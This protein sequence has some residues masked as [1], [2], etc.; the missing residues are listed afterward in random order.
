[1][2]Y[3]YLF[4]SIKSVQAVQ[5]QSKICILDI[6]VQGVRTIKSG[7]SSAS[8]DPIYVFIAPPSMEALESRLRQRNTEEEA[9]ILKRLNNAKTELEYGLT[10][11]NFD[12]V[13][14]NDNLDETCSEIAK[15]LREWYPDLLGE[16]MQQP[17]TRK[18]HVPLVD[19]L[20]FPKTEHG[21]K[22][23]L[24]EID[25]DCQL[26]KYNQAHLTYQATGVHIK[27]GGKLE[28]PLPPVEQNGS[29]VEW[30]VTLLDE[31]LEGLDLEFGV[32]CIVD[33]DEVMV[34]QMRRI[35]SPS[36]SNQADEDVAATSDGVSS[37]GEEK[38][39]HEGEETPSAKGKF[40]VANSAPV[41]LFIKCDNS[42][43]W[44][45]PKKINYSFT[46][47]PP[48]DEDMIQRSNR[49]KSVL[50][51]ILEERAVVVGATLKLKERLDA[52]DRIKTDLL[53]KMDQLN[54]QIY[55]EK[56][57]IE[58]TRQRADEAEQTASS[59][60]QEIKDTLVAVKREE[61][62]IDSC[63]RQI[64]SLEEE[65]A[66]LKKQCEGLKI[67]RQVRLEEKTQLEMKAETCRQERIQL[68]G[69]I[70][71]RKAEEKTK[72]AALTSLEKD[73]LLMND[74]MN[75]LEKER[76]SKA[77]E[78]ASYAKEVSFFQKQIDALKL[79]LIEPKTN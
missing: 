17:P 75:D 23:F 3:L 33:G 64:L 39:G 72:L 52:L 16:K 4:F 53:N 12:R 32:S 79:R 36:V 58:E 77:D 24:S 60:A 11:G 59:K 27:A 6:D 13:F 19:P 71:T 5:N 68:Q 54:K 44:F 70:S 38:R 10:G 37:N 31:H 45:T 40:T 43:S 62:S 34:P 25:Q 18:Y 35:L 47:I 56:K 29:T 22:A 15:Q 14:I 63:S 51:R 49:A 73:H 61:E 28:I 65:C 20:S 48:V 1:M 57:S 42:Y 30:T 67:E 9:S 78:E 76:H 55:D 41:Q 2:H 46:I 26:E 74:S 50:P 66:K 21:L 7:P 69:E 8:L